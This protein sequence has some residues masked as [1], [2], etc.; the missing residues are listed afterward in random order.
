M[1]ILDKDKGFICKTKVLQ[2]M[3]YDRTKRYTMPQ[4]Q[5]EDDIQ[6]CITLAEEEEFACLIL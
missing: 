5:Y 1:P 4:W 3:I 6:N 2:I